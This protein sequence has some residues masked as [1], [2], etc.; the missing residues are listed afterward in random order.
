MWRLVQLMDVLNEGRFKF[1][2]GFRINLIR[3][4]TKKKYNFF[5]SFSLVV[6]AVLVLQVSKL[7]VSG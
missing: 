3:Y 4:L 5:M 7:S 2:N 1:C 6:K